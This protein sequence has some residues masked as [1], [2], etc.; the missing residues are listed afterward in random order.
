MEDSGEVEAVADLRED[1]G[2]ETFARAEAGRLV[3]A[4]V[5][6][7]AVSMPSPVVWPGRMMWPDCSPPRLR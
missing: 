3:R 6:M 5:A 2:S 7:R 4:L 1:T